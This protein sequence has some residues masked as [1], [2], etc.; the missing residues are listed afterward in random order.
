[1]QASRY[2]KIIFTIRKSWVRNNLDTRHEA[3][4]SARNRSID[5]IK[6]VVTNR[7]PLALV[8]DLQTSR[9][10]IRYPRSHKTKIAFLCVS[11]RGKSFIIYIWLDFRIVLAWSPPQSD[12]YA[13]CWNAIE[14]NGV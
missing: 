6:V 8:M 5:M 13:L 11:Y 14:D 10:T 9:V 12:K 1:M 3:K 4:L 7:P 2:V